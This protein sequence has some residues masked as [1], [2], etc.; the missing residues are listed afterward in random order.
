M[1]QGHGD[2]A[3]HTR[4]SSDDQYVPQMQNMELVLLGFSLDL[5]QSFRSMLPTSL[6]KEV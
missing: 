5:V 6:S 2:K 1:W 3:A 4:W